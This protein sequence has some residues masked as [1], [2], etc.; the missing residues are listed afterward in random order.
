MD[1]SLMTQGQI[2]TFA[3]HYHQISRD[4]IHKTEKYTQDWHKKGGFL[5][6]GVFHFSIPFIHLC[7]FQMDAGVRF[8]ENRAFY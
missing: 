6:E 8:I 3:P 7:N 1:N 4:F 2:M 5:L